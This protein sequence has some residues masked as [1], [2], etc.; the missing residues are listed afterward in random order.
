MFKTIIIASWLMLGPD[1]SGWGGEGE[2]RVDLDFK[3]KATCEQVTS[4][5]V[6]EATAG[7]GRLIKL[8]ECKHFD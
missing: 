5:I 8:S 6:A 1:N 2:T 7:G 4:D 3:D